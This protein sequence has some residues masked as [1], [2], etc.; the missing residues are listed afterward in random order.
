MFCLL[1]PSVCGFFVHV[2]GGT[3]LVDSMLADDSIKSQLNETN[4]SQSNR[5]SYGC[6]FGT[7]PGHKQRKPP[8]QAPNKIAKN[9]GSLMYNNNY[10][11]VELIHSWGG[12]GI[13][14]LLTEG[15]YIY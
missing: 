11:C 1:F 12:S 5:K 15:V 7:E 9:K 4:Q 14:L 2:N 13:P 8:F 3:P 10:I 6:Q